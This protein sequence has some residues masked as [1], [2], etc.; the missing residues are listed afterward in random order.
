MRWSTHYY[1]NAGYYYYFTPE[2]SVNLFTPTTRL[3]IHSPIKTRQTITNRITTNS[4]TRLR[5][6]HHLDLNAALHY[7]KGK[8]YYE[9]YKY[10]QLFSDYHLEDVIVGTDTISN[11]N[12]VRQK[13]LDNDFYGFTLSSNFQNDYLEFNAGC[14]VEPLQGKTL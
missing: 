3:T 2:D 6:S 14:C 9:E 1:N 13:W 11:S 8:G 10:A 5:Q 4:I 7:T 12:L